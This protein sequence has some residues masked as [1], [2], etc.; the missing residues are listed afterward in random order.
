[1][2]F[3]IV[4]IVAIGLVSERS[5]RRSIEQRVSSIE[6]MIKRLPLVLIAIGTGTFG[7][8]PMN[9]GEP[10]QMMHLSPGV[11]A[12]YRN[13][14]GSCVQ[15]SLGM[16]GVH[17]N[18]LNAASLLFD[19]EYGPAERGG[20]WPGRVAEYC[21]RRKI[22]AWNVTGRTVDDTMPGIKWAARTG[23]F[24]AVG[25]GTAH[26]QTL[27][28]YDPNT[29]TFF[30]CNNNSTNQVDRYSEADFRA[31]HAQSGPWV[32][33]LEKPSSPPPRFEAWWVKQ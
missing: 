10:V 3:L 20:S 7:A 26:F 33:I 16:A 21:D 28:G 6:W 29:N 2:E 19:S 22:I 24:A 27:Y 18:N 14:D 15:C 13:P 1:M 31:L 9:A 23:R 32:V 5:K 25:L 8:S 11:R 12:W 4:V 17:C 30:V